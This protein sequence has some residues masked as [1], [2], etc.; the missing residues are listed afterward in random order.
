M[1]YATKTRI[2]HTA[3][4]LLIRFF[5]TDPHEAP[6]LMLNQLI[7]SWTFNIEGCSLTRTMAPKPHIFRWSVQFTERLHHHVL[8][9]W[10]YWESCSAVAGDHWLLKQRNVLTSF[11]VSHRVCLVW[12]ISLIGDDGHGEVMFGSR[13]VWIWI[14]LI[15]EYSNRFWVSVKKKPWELIHVF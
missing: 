2:K 7:R 10:S 13:E 14:S 9:S 11:M 4:F 6:R 5:G 12:W 3:D 1:Q 15:G 8:I